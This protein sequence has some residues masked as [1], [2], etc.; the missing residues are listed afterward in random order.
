MKRLLVFGTLAVVLFGLVLPWPT[1]AAKAPPTPQTYTVLVG[2]ENTS[3]AF[4]PD[5]FLPQLGD[6]S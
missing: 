3:R 1:L 6:H 2:Y 5:G 4:R